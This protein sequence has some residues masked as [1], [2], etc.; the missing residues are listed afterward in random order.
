MFVVTPYPNV[1]YALDLTRAGA[2][3]RWKYE[4]KPAAAAQGVA[5]CD[6]V[7]RGVVVADGRVY[8]N[9]LDGHTIAVDTSP[10]ASCGAPRSATRP[11]GDR[12]RVRGPTRAMLAA[13]RLRLRSPAATARVAHVRGRRARR[14]RR[15]E[16]MERRRVPHDDRGR[17]AVRR[18]ERD[19][20]DDRLLSERRRQPAARARAERAY[21]DRSGQ[22]DVGLRLGRRN[23][24][25][26]VAGVEP[27][28]PPAPMRPAT[29]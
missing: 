13:E 5:C 19:G 11:H 20:D 24:S 25:I 8:M 21:R 6:V 29:S 1:L 16:R 28:Q 27:G 14:A 23:L 15:I 3:V 26:D 17:P 7:N 18:G 10:D 9:T 4:P 22:P 12:A 2:P